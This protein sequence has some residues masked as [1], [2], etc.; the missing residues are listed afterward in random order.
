M[1]EAEV[2][3]QRGKMI[4]WG[5]QLSVVSRLEPALAGLLL[6][7]MAILPVVELALRA[8]LN[9]G[10]P[11]ASSYV[12]SLTLWVGFT[13]AMLAARE[14]QHLSFFFGRDLLPAGV[15]PY[16][17]ALTAASQRS[18]RPV[19]VGRRINLFVPIFNRRSLSGDGCLRGWWNRFFR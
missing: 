14:D 6:L 10:I 5:Q 1:A 9:A 7:L 18:W 2:R 4:R 19:C 3:I 13:G 11:A 16:A 12:Q 8:V 17:E 15:R